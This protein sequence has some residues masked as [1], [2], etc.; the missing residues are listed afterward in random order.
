MPE[1]MVSNLGRVMRL[2]SVGPMPHGGTRQYGGKPHIGQW[3][4]GPGRYG[5][6]VLP[7][8]GKTYKVASLVCEAFNGPKPFPKWDCMHIDEDARNNRADNLR[9][10]TRKEN[11]NA[12]GYI[13]YCK[14]RTG[15]NS[16]AW[17]GGR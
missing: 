2:P 7:F 15:E 6:Y 17:K 14:T 3:A 13:A 1:Y 8:R 9:W 4:K 10:G 16:P 11:Q 12:P 5:R